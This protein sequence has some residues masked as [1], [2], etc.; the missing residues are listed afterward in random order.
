MVHLVT[1]HPETVSRDEGPDHHERTD[2]IVDVMAFAT[3]LAV[4]RQ[5][6]LSNERLS[7]W[8]GGEPSWA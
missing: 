5:E 7:A 2:I 4:L 6:T 8:L 3:F 1:D